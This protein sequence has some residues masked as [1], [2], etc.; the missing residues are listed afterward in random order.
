MYGLRH[1]HIRIEDQ[2]T[3]LKIDIMIKLI[4]KKDNISVTPIKL[5]SVREFLQK[6][7]EDNV[8]L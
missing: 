3:N 2:Q 4:C 1:K 8:F 7:F 6:T 5:F